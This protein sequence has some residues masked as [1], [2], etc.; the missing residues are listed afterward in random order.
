MNK[1]RLLE[2]LEN[3]AINDCYKKFLKL[4]YNNDLI[5]DHYFEEFGQSSVVDNSLI[6]LADEQSDYEVYK[7]NV[8]TQQ[9]ELTKVKLLTFDRSKFSEKHKD[10]S[11]IDRDDYMYIY[12]EKDDENFTTWRHIDK[13]ILEEID[14]VTGNNVI[15]I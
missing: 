2:K 6:E 14:P 8:H 7:T 1:Y 13:S 9:K 3:L 11:L 10:K 4:L 12:T 15:V 5:L